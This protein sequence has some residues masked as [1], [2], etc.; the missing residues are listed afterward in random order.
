MEKITVWVSC[1]YKAIYDYIKLYRPNKILEIGSWSQWIWRC[2]EIKF[3]WLDLTTSDYETNEKLINK[4][5]TFI[6]WS[7]LD[8][9]IKDQTYDFVFSADMIEH[10]NLKDRETVFKEALRVCKS[11]W[12]I[13]LTFP[14]WFRGKMSD[15]ALFLAIKFCNIFKKTDIPWWLI[16]HLNIKYPSSKW[17]DRIINNILGKNK[18]IKNCLINNSFVITFYCIL[19][20]TRLNF[21]DYKA[22]NR[23]L[24]SNT[25]L[26]SESLFWYRKFILIQKI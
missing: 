26:D 25:S 23:I 11:W 22:A 14:C 6:K 16:E 17:I 1:R 15:Y 12:H 24:N 3:D 4:N 9:P 19:S 2:Y 13:I 10:I 8:I 20:F 18:L 21:I 5:M 7:A